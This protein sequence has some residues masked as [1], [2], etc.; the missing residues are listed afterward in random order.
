M[1]PWRA[2]LIADADCRAI[3]QGCEFAQMGLGL[4]HAEMAMGTA[5]LDRD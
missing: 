3:D 1:L 4:R 2:R 5:D